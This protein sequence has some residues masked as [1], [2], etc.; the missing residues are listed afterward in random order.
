MLIAEDE[1]ELRIGLQRIFEAK[2]FDVTA[3]ADGREALRHLTTPP[4][5]DIA[6]LDVMMPEMT[7]LAVLR[8]ARSAAV[9][10]PILL[11]TV[12]SEEHEKVTGLALGADD[13]VTKPFSNSE[14]IARVGALLRRHNMAMQN[15]S[16]VWLFGDVE[17]NFSARTAKKGAEPMEITNKE[18]DLLHYLVRH[19][20]K[21]VSRKEILRN[22]WGLPLSVETRTMDRHI[23][24]LRKKIEP[25]RHNPTYIHT[26][27][28]VGYRVE[29]CVP[30][31]QGR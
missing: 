18:W 13:Y 24:S 27:F 1:Y 9:T 14:L 20:G 26:V 28:S 4:Y 17:V 5:F 15:I 23:K 12:K 10:T 22:V 6:I 16:D 19:R 31:N 21:S 30:A 29:G 2:H 11:L 3:V 25:D 7:G 8:E